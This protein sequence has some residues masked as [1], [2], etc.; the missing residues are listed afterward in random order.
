MS[1][2]GLLIYCRAE[3]LLSYLTA[4]IAPPLGLDQPWLIYYLSI[5]AQCLQLAYTPCCTQMAFQL[6]LNFGISIIAP[7]LSTIAH[8]GCTRSGYSH[9]S[10]ST[11]FLAGRHNCAISHNNEL[12]I[13]EMAIGSFTNLIRMK[14]VSE[15]SS[16]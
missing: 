8:T 6:Q 15:A 14:D 5:Y 13:I 2:S 11:P 16:I 12:K 4:C 3:R 10:H 9:E 1:R 7:P